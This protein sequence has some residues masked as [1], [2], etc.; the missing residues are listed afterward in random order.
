MSRDLATARAD[1]QLL[2]QVAA[3][4]LRYGYRRLFFFDGQH[5]LPH[6]LA[7]AEGGPGCCVLGTFVKLVEWTGE[8]RTVP[9]YRLTAASASNHEGPCRAAGWHVKDL[10]DVTGGV[11]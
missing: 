9:V 5:E 6:G 8:H 3:R 11:K 2:C 1:Q 10:L 7:T 4:V